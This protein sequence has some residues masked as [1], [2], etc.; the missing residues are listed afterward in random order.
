M[1]FQNVVRFGLFL[2]VAAGPLVSYGQF[3]PPTKEELSMK[4]DP[5]APGAAAV[6]LYREETADDPHH[7][8]TV[9]AQFRLS[10]HWK[11]FEPDGIW[12]RDSL[13]RA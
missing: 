6:Y 13:G 2:L 11:Q 3:Q 10:R 9:Y 4:S 5:K 1:R 8:S 12:H 7:F